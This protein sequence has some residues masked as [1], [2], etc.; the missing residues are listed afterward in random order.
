MLVK[1]FRR[2]AIAILLFVSACSL[3]N[4]EGPSVTCGSLG[5]GAKNA[6]QEGIIATCRSST[7]NYQACDDQSSC[8]ATWQ[9]AGRYRCT[10]N[11][12]PPNLTVSIATGSG[13]SG[14]GSGGKASAVVG[15]S[16]SSSGGKAS[17]VVGGTS[18]T[19]TGGALSGSGGSP[20]QGC[21]PAGPCPVASTGSRN[22][23][24]YTVDEQ[25]AYFSDCES[26]WS[27]PKAGGFPTT[28]ATGLNGCSHGN[29]EQDATDLYFRETGLLSQS[30]VRVS[31]QG[32]PV[33]RLVTGINAAS[34]VLASDPLNLYW[35]D[36]LALTKMPKLGGAKEIVATVG[37]ACFRTKRFVVQGDYVYWGQGNSIQRVKTTGPFPAAPAALPIGNSPRDFAVTD[38]NVFFTTVQQQGGL[39]GNLPLASGQWT[40]L[41]SNQPTPTSVTVDGS[42]VYWVSDYSEI[43]KAN[44]TGG[45]AA[46]VAK[47]VGS[48]HDLGRIVTDEAHVYWA[49]GQSLMR[50]PK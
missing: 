49:E 50:A 4:R 37:A 5:D 12:L 11:E 30:V 1:M 38:T 18:S 25:N 14:A 39:V 48:Q 3:A 44:V 32:G 7:V 6:C 26:V 34:A 21:D 43:R 29:I 2:S 20:G 16:G 28:I 35:I 10:E 23:D 15:G 27:F 47:E 9:L 33:T 19:A 42:F 36:G 31:K 13:G 24:W 8:S 17:A 41:A 45:S 40:E 46:L 22:I